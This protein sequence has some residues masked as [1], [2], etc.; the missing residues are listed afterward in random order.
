MA[1]TSEPNIRFK[2]NG[3]FIAGSFSIVDLLGTLTG[4]DSGGGVIG[5]TGSGGG[6]GTNVATEVL[7]PTTSGSNITLDLTALAHTFVAIEVVFRN[8]QNI[9]PISSWSRTGNTITVF[10][11]DNTEAFQVQY[12]Y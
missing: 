10:N 7:T 6:T 8:G 2:N 9:T 1:R 12:T 5:I 3:V 4:A 11:A